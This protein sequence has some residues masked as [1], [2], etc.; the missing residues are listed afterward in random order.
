MKLTVQKENFLSKEPRTTW[1]QQGKHRPPAK[2]ATA[3]LKS[4]LKNTSTVIHPSYMPP[5]AK[6]PVDGALALPAYFMSAAE[7]LLE[8]MGPNA[9]DI[10]VHDLIEAYNTFSQRIR[11]QIRGILTAEVPLPALNSLAECCHQLGE[12]LRRDLKRTREE[13]FPQSRLT[14]VGLDSVQSIPEL[15]EEEIRISR[16]LALLS[17]QV[18]RLLSDIFSFP[19]LHSIFSTNDLRLILGELLV[20]GSASHLPGPASRRTWTLLVWI[21]SV[22][23]LP[24]VV[25]S[26]AKCEIATVLKRAVNGEIGQDQAKLDALQASS[27]LLKQ[28]PSLFI[29]PLST[30]FPCILQHLIADS[31]NIRLQAVNAL[32][33]FALAKINTLST[34]ANSCHTSIAETLTT[35]INA[36][37]SKLKSIQS[38]LRL[39]PLIT[40]ALT[41]RSPKNPAD[42]PFWV[43]QLLASFVVLLGDSVFSNPRAIKLTLQSLQ[44]IAVHKQNVVKR[45]HPYVWKCLVWVFSRLPISTD[46]KTRDSVFLTL[47][48]D[49]RGSIGLALVLSLLA[50]APNDGSCDTSDSVKKILKV[51]KN[52][53]S[54]SEPII[55]A[56]GVVLLTQLLYTPTPPTT[57]PYKLNILVP[58]L[59]D[60]SLVPS[61][62]DTVLTTV[63]DLERLDP[64]QVRQL[65]D[66]EILRHWDALADRWV[67]ATNISLNPGFEALKLKSPYLTTPEY[68]QNLLHGWQSLL[69]MP[70]DLSQ[71]FAHLTPQDPFAIKIGAL[72]RSF[73]A[74]SESSEAQVQRL[75]LVRK[76]WRTMT[77]VFQRDWLSSLAET[78][79]GAVLKQ[80]YNLA[81]E[82]IRGSWAE[83]CSELISLGL[84]SAVGIVRDQGEA[85][86]PAELQR[87]LWLLAVKSIG[88][89]DAPAPWM[90]VAYLISIPF[91]AWRMTKSEI[92]IWSRLLKAAMRNADS[93][94]ATLFVEYVFENIK[95]LHRLSDSPNEISTLLSHVNL[96]GRTALPQFTISALVKILNDIY[97]QALAPTSLQI[98][99]RIRDI[100]L[101]VPSNLA[102]PLLLELQDSVCKWL[103]V[104]ANVLGEDARREITECLFSAP[105]STIH[106][107]EPSGKNLVLISRFLATVADAD[108][109]EKFWRVTYHGRDEFYDLYPESIKISLRAFTDVFGGSLAAD[110]SMENHSQMESSCA[111]D[112]Q[113]SQAVPTSSFDYYADES[114]YPLEADTVAMGDTR[115]MDVEE[116]SASTAR[117]PSSPIQPA[118]SPPATSP[119][120]RVRPVFSAALDQLQDYSSR[121]DESSVLSI[122]N[123]S[124]SSHSTV[125]AKTPQVLSQSNS[126]TR[127]SKRV[128]SG[129]DDTSASKRR[130]T[131]PEIEFTPRESNAV[132]GP[133]R[134]AGESI[135]EPV[136]RRDSVNLSEHASSQPIPSPRKRKGKRKVVLDYVEIPTYEESRRHRL[137][138]ALPTPPPSFR[139]PPPRQHN[140][141]DEEEDYDSWEANLSVS[142]VQHVQ[143]ELGGTSAH[144]PLASVDETRMD[145]DKSGPHAQP[146]PSSSRR[147]HT[148]PIPPRERHPT[149][150]RRSTTSA[151]LGALQHALA[152][153]SDDASQTPVPILMQA[154]RLVH[155]IGT[156]LNEQMSRELNRR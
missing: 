15:Y 31:A 155:E 16:D 20:L 33:R 77:N 124:V 37:T 4:I 48:Q 76:M 61:K 38:E 105:L 9:D 26:P 6:A 51:V 71:G 40:A 82:Q 39:R 116:G 143:H 50:V 87:Q 19:A 94:Q 42:S 23:T 45:L 47:I 69:L 151:R 10:S 107:L 13:P 92:D 63:R 65:T 52:M 55:Q 118:T 114:R 22:Q 97:P 53:M 12:V 36:Q 146:D 18:L 150:L 32:G 111:P 110:L 132:A 60:G 100:I 117:P 140:P 119:P 43:V 134:R 122:V 102:L 125:R 58:Q 108:A 149:P 75:V 44:E 99:Q 137:E 17:Q 128:R 84:P 130:K 126:S 34:T 85:Q 106:G 30:V 127:S 64:R 28:Y 86:M 154:S 139:P 148:V 133:S 27:Q 156:A 120:P 72:I 91:G 144:P 113:P 93:N 98:I 68:R 109:F 1:T 129:V 78:V 21:L 142:Q 46:D 103:E 29:S 138:R 11:A 136:S 56:E 88:K 90:D 62:G 80:G 153:V 66:A 121:L 81:D 83:L 49:L 74:P 67:Q 35:F 8:S 152:L 141:P 135:S 123:A 147:S 96:T 104:D 89:S 24:S 73:I 131:S 2:V 3:P 5:A 59:F 101:S 14:S 112:S 25:L 7:T 145:V 95:D 70:S 41:T 54:N 79:L 115:F 57:T